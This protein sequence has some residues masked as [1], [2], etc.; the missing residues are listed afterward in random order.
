[1][2]PGDRSLVWLERTIAN[3]AVTQMLPA[4]VVKGGTAMRLRAGTDNVRFSA[5]LDTAR[6]VG[7]DVDTFITR[8]EGNLRAGWAGFTGVVIERR[9]A[10]PR[11][12]PPDYVMR[13][14]DVKLA[15][16]T[17]SLC[18]VEF[19][20][21]H[22]EIG[23]TTRP[24]LRPVAA[25]IVELFSSLGLP[26]PEPVPLLATEYQIAQKL[27]ACTT[28]TAAG[29]NDR[30][31]DL[32][33]IQLLYELD[34]PDPAELAAIGTRL[35]ASRRQGAWPPT[36]QAH[37]GW[38]ALYAAAATGIAVRPLAEAVVWVNERI[39]ETARLR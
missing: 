21:G 9:P 3:V 10:N 20:L 30:A 15:Y 23:S 33:D 27:H 5:D 24:S 7:V 16:R 36:V 26:K 6:P 32:V 29:G 14:F 34:P 19:E 17:R 39:A 31:H 11:D 8:F 2:L 22:D 37:P 13:P 12:V 38:D 1:M 18:T 28:L 35:F 4:G 25:G